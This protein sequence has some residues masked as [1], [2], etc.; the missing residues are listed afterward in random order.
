MEYLFYSL[1]SVCII[2]LYPLFCDGLKNLLKD[3][4]LIVVYIISCFIK[5]WKWIKKKI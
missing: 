1:V 2:V 4:I 3:I 5:L